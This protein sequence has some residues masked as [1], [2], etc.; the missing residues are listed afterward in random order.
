MRETDLDR[1]NKL[2]DWY[3]QNRSTAGKEILTTHTPEK[4]CKMV[5]V[6]RTAKGEWQSVVTHRGRKILAGSGHRE[7]VK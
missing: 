5:G 4:L 7:P 1:L 6:P 2:I 3:E